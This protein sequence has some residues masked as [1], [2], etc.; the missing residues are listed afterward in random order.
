MSGEEIPFCS[1][2][3]EYDAGSV[4][5]YCP[6]KSENSIMLCSKFRIKIVQTDVSCNGIEGNEP[7]QVVSLECGGGKSGNDRPAND[8]TQK[9]FLICRLI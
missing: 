1:E 3:G 6:A 4:C 7:E 9:E 2:N 5:E 8:H